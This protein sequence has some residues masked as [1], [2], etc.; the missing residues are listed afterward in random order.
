MNMS[1]SRLFI[2]TCALAGI[3]VLA[4]GKTKIVA[5]NLFSALCN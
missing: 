5:A 3:G 4:A 2:K 1:D